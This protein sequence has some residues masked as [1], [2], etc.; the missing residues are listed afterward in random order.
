MYILI[1]AN[2]TMGRRLTGLVRVD[3][4]HGGKHFADLAFGG[5]TGDNPG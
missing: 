2:I 4:E 1:R 5:L 3:G